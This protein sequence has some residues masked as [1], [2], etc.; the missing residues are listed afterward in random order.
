MTHDNQ[1]GIVAIVGATGRSPLPGH[2][3][4]GTMKPINL[5][6]PKRKTL[7]LKNYDYS[8]VGFYFVTIC[9]RNRECLFGEIRDGQIRLNE[10]GNVVQDEWHRSSSIRLEIQLDQFVVMPNHIHGIVVINA[11][12]VSLVK[13]NVGATGRSP[14]PNQKPFFCAT[15]GDN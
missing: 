4:G 12:S 6:K 7:R 8:S 5:T 10:W 9:T 3:G 11:S 15:G 1:N 14:L 2:T 13:S